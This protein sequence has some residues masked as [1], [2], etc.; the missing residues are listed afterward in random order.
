METPLASPQN[1]PSQEAVQHELLFRLQEALARLPA[2]QR[3]AV[4]LHHLEGRSLIR[5][6]R[7]VALQTA[8]GGRAGASRSQETARMAARKRGVSPRPVF[9]GAHAGRDPSL[10]CRVS[11]ARG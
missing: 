10:K 3:L 11:A 9:C 8:G 4:E 5:G 2:N 7:R 6:R 1:T